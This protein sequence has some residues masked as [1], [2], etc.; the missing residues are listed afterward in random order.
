MTPADRL[1]A[2]PFDLPYERLM[3]EV[4]STQYSRVPIY[5]GDRSN[6]IGILHVRDLFSFDR[7]RAAGQ[8]S[9]LRLVLRRPLFVDE[10]TPLE[11]LLREFQ[12][13]QLHMALVTAS[14]SLVGIVTMDD[15]QEELFGEIEA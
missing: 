15:V 9:D 1:F 11:E 14:G 3:E 6:V 7:R 5:E 12:R 10:R 2:L 4:R 13:T 8:Q